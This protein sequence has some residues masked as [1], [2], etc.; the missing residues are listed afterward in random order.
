MNRTKQ[1]KT[2]FNTQG[3]NKIIFSIYKTNLT[4]LH[5]NKIKQ[6]KILQK[7]KNKRE[8]ER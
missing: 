2:K 4:Y 7:L 6:N 1:Q 5:L 8:R 3:I